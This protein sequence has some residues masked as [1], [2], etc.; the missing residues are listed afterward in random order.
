MSED[1]EENSGWS[2][3]L[4]SAT[5]KALLLGEVLLRHKFTI[6]CDIYD[7]LEHCVE[8]A[9]HA[10]ANVA[11]ANVATGS[12]SISVSAGCEIDMSLLWVPFSESVSV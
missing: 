12:I 2:E 4:G 1:A 11:A 6:S 3:T 7:F 10:H 8:Q 5:N 9:V